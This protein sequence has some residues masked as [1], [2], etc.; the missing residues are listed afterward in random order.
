MIIGVARGMGKQYRLSRDKPH[1]SAPAGAVISDAAGE[2]RTAWASVRGMSPDR[3]D[4]QDAEAGR[5]EIMVTL[6]LHDIP[7]G[8]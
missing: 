3:F 6:D 7:D 2:A 4:V 1:P 5:G 8:W